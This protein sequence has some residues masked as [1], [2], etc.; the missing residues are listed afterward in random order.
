MDMRWAAAGV[1]AALSLAA[2]TQGRAADKPATVR[3]Q[4]FRSQDYQAFRPVNDH[5]FNIRVGA[6]DYYRV[7]TAGSCPALT[8]PEAVL[9]TQT[10]GSDFICGPLD[11]DL[12]VSEN[13][14]DGPS[15]PCIVD[16]Q[17]KLTPAEAAALPKA[18]KP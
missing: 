13:G 12:R 6:N 2:A 5:A 3:G 18:Q 11:W 1:S 8:Y 16:S 15:E 10:L 14:S 7:E 4:C 9:V 17:R